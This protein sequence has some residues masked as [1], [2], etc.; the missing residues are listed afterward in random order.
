MSTAPLPDPEIMTADEVAV[1][2]KYKSGDAIRS[3]VRT[4][5]LP[6]IRTSPR[7]MR[8]R[9]HDVL[10]WIE[11]QRQVYLPGEAPAEGA[12]ATRSTPPAAPKIDYLA[13][14]RKIRKH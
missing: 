14:M 13:E 4:M 3:M 2:L 11:R 5:G 6:C 8:F 10:A 12:R 9:R 7:S 1:M